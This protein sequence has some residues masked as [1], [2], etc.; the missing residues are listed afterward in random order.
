MGGHVTPD[1]FCRLPTCPS[2]NLAYSFHDAL[3]NAMENWATEDDGSRRVNGQWFGRWMQVGFWGHQTRFKTEIGKAPP[4]FMGIYD[5]VVNERTL[6]TSSSVR[7]L[8]SDSGTAT[9]AIVSPSAL[10]TSK[11]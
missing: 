7:G 9:T 3:Y 11:E 2:A 1:P 8:I 4:E 5:P 10:N 6:K